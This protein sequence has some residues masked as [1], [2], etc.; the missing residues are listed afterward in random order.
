MQ[1]TTNINKKKGA[2]LCA[3][4]VI[5]ILG[6]YLAVILFPLVGAAFGELLAL[7]FLLIYGG[8]IIAVIAGII[9]ALRQR[10]K[11]I[12]GGEEEDAKIY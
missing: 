7:G 6:I 10:L 4:V 11:E 8:V 1:D 2:I 3:A 5:G 12:E 9:T